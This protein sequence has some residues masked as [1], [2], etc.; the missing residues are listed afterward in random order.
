MINFFKKHI[1]LSVFLIYIV[2]TLVLT[3][4]VVFDINEKIPGAHDAFETYSY[5]FQNEKQSICEYF[6]N[7]PENFLRKTFDFK[8]YIFI[9]HQLIGDPLAYNIIWL[10]SF[11]FSSFGAYLLCNYIT[12]NKTVSFVGGLVYG[13][14]P[15]HFAYAM[16]FGG[17]GHIEFI[18][19]FVLFFLKYFKRIK[20]RYLLV[21][22]VFFALIMANE[23][24][25]AI[26]TV[27]FIILFSIYYFLK[28]KLYKNKKFVIT[29]LVFLTIGGIFTIYH[30]WGLLKITYS[31]N[32]FLNPG[33]QAAIMFS[34]DIVALFTPSVYHPLWGDFFS[35]N[36][37]YKSFTGFPA[38]WTNYIG[39]IALFFIV[40]AILNYKKNKNI[41]FW[42][43]IFIF[44]LIMSLG[45]Y[46]HF[47]GTIE[48]KIPLPYL[49][50][51]KFIPFFENIRS[52]ARAFIYSSLAISVLVSF[53][54]KCFF[55][56]NKIKDNKY[57][58][59][60]L[61]VIILIIIDFWSVPVN[62]SV[63]IPAFF[64]E[65]K[66]D[67]EK[68][69]ILQPQISL[70]HAV[71]SYSMYYNSIHNKRV[72]GGHHFARENS[73]L[74]NF[75]KN[76]PVINDL[77]YGYP[78][79]KLT[80]NFISQDYQNISNFILNKNNIKYIVLYK[81]YAEIY[82]SFDNFIKLNNFIRNNIKVD[83][84]LED[85][86]LLV[87]KIKDYQPKEELI[88]LQ[89]NNG[90]SEVSYDKNGVYISS[91]KSQSA[92]IN[93]N[94][95]SKSNKKALLNLNTRRANNFR[96]L[97]IIFNNKKIGEY[98][99]GQ[100]EKPIDL[101]IDD[102]K[103][104][105]NTLK[106]N[107]LDESGNKVN[108]SDQDTVFVN[109]D[110]QEIEKINKPNIYNNLEKLK[111]NILQIPT[112]TSYGYQNEVI[113]NKTI[114]YEELIRRCPSLQFNKV[115]KVDGLKSLKESLNKDNNLRQGILECFN[116]LGI[117][118]IEVDKKHLNNNQLAELLSIF[119]FTLDNKEIIENNNEKIAF[120]INFG[121]ENK[122][123]KWGSDFEE[124]NLHEWDIVVGLE[125][126][127]K[128]IDSS[129]NGNKA[130]KI[131]YNLG[132]KFNG[133]VKNFNYPAQEAEV[134]GYFKIEEWAR[135]YIDLYFDFIYDK[136]NYFEYPRL[137]EL[138]NYSIT[139][140]YRAKMKKSSKAGDFGHNL[141][142]T[143][144]NKIVIKRDK[145]G[146]FSY[147]E[148]DKEIISFVHEF[149]PRIYGFKI[150]VAGC[151]KNSKINLKIDN[152][153]LRYN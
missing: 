28:Y 132:Q 22:I 71:G 59:G 124:N 16:P 147:Y 97:E 94:N 150:G 82:E 27:L 47:F 74:Y 118:Y 83:K 153:Q 119:F 50:L 48:P 53:G 7:K 90:W 120:K 144:W 24:H 115:F 14:S 21:S 54:V 81:K 123:V 84:Y 87:Y 72:V 45:P 68:F 65:L 125:D 137:L 131:N 103:P 89:K 8:S 100:E 91:M 116:N 56:K 57:K 17:A 62:I 11:L 143:N 92:L 42:I 49:L 152:F 76:T 151:C 86:E 30:F 138:G 127:F 41:I 122:T 107:I 111:G 98:W 46:L 73:K 38:E 134:E 4:P 112:A 33:I 79:G 113:K 146:R 105:D 141:S 149:K 145:N 85:K 88:I 63:N 9:L 106:F 130:L 36:I 66:N 1:N 70:S 39:F 99:I 69:A 5:A 142:V 93:I 52:V 20:I 104:K 35:K 25:F 64:K 96:K 12:K 3:V 110:Y 136:N 6:F 31:E 26:Y 40:I 109:I 15:L 19:F 95:Y 2:L 32:N 128:L 58:Y 148:N 78:Y 37:A 102:I 129:Y 60:I 29:N 140:Y 43:G 10:L 61:V 101:Y 23:P 44:F 18:P 67:K 114:E 34:N 135:G 75:E 55:N 51:R 80:D 133:L 126:N 108:I 139:D 77:I 13:F 117:R 121:D